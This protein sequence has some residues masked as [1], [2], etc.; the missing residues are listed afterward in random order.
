[1]AKIGASSEKIN[2]LK[3]TVQP[4]KNILPQPEAKNLG[5]QPQQHS[6][7]Q[8]QQQFPLSAPHAH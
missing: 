6:L 7:H 5:S 8:Y 2:L 3:I 4:R 1:M